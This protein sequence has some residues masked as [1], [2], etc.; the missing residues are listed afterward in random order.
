[1]KKKTKIVATI[2]DLRCDVDFIKKLYEE[3]MNVV[4]LNTAHQTHKDTLR[5]VKNVR[6]VSLKIPLLL[7]TKGPEIRTNKFEEER[8]FKTGEVIIIKGDA[9]KLPD[10]KT[11]YVSYEGIVED[12]SVGKS[13]L[14]DDGVLEF[15][16]IKKSSGGLVCKA[17]NNGAIKGRKSVNVPGVK[18]NLPSLTKKDRDYIEFAAKNK[19][20]FIAH[21]F[22]RNKKDVLAV[23]KILDKYKSKAKIIAK[24]ENQEGVDNLDEILDVAY[25]VMVARGD[26]GIE[27]P[28]ERIPLIQYGM[29]KK[30]ISRKRPVIVATQMLH[31][32]IDNPRPTRAEVADIANAIRSGTDAIMLSG[33]TAYGDY[34]VE[35]VRVMSKISREVEKER[36]EKLKDVEITE[37]DNEVAAYLAKVAVR[38]SSKLPI[39]A[40]ICDSTT[41][42]TA[43]Y[44]SAFRGSKLVFT[45]CYDDATMRHLALSYGVYAARIDK[46][47]TH[48]KFI[49]ISLNTLLKRKEFKKSDLM[50]VLAGNYGPTNGANFVEI[51]TIENLLNDKKRIQT[52]D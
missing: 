50:V 11:L 31:T 42:R 46:T 4:R 38:A 3:G 52:H 1:M 39:K 17:M 8:H 32:M 16:V 24:I 15:K 49:K 35:A 28:A 43:R 37:L 18:I 47:K 30:C 33:E 20:D 9:K 13:I 51:S 5:V 12:V 27:I 10:A 7:D 25:G 26:L 45:Q 40:I 23:Q 48:D 19:L 36:E 41:G 6:A 29:V 2:S 44:L 22:V 14:I 34:P 21:S